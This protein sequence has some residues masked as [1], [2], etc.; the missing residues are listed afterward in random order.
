VSASVFECAFVSIRVKDFNPVAV[1]V[2]VEEF[3]LVIEL[4][5]FAGVVVLFD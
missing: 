4:P 2:A 3:P 1:F 5:E